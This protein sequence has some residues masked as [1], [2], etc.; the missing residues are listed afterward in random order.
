MRKHC[1]HRQPLDERGNL[2]DWG[3]ARGLG[4][5]PLGQTKGCWVHY[6]P[7]GESMDVWPQPGSQSHICTV[8]VCQFWV[9]KASIRG[10]RQAPTKHL[11]RT[12]IKSKTSELYRYSRRIQVLKVHLVTTAIGRC[13]GRYR[14]SVNNP[15]KWQT[16]FNF[17]VDSAIQP[18]HGAV[19]NVGQPATPTE[20]YTAS[21]AI[22]AP[23]AS[24]MD[25]KKQLR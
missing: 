19:R 7:C 9:D 8:L 11:T 5:L 4:G 13:T 17:H 18:R 12:E 2:R 10:I 6:E 14:Q 16:G 23:S 15:A 3:M 25:S 21:Y 20:H 1:R 24:G 22:F